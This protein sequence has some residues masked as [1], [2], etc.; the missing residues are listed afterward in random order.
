MV[1][2][3]ENIP[4]ECSP[5]M[6]YWDNWYKAFFVF[7]Y[8]GGTYEDLIIIINF[9]ILTVTHKNLFY[10]LLPLH[11]RSVSTINILSISVWINQFLRVYFD[12]IH[13][14]SIKPD[15]RDRLSSWWYPDSNHWDICDSIA[16]QRSQSKGHNVILSQICFTSSENGS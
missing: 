6:T 9:N 8:D 12:N 3:K 13:C 11:I 2:C 4:N 10:Y 5:N 14:G 7:L 15:Q 16:L 1:P